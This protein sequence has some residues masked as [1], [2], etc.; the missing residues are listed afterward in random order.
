MAS[1]E[2][3]MSTVARLPTLPVTILVAALA[4]LPAGCY[5]ITWGGSSFRQEVDVSP[6]HELRLHPGIQSLRGVLP[7]WGTVVAD[8]EEWL[9]GFR[10]HGEVEQL[11]CALG[12]GDIHLDVHAYL[13][14]RVARAREAF[15]RE[16]ANIWPSRDTAGH[17]HGGAGDERYCVSEV[18]E[19]ENHCQVLLGRGSGSYSSAVVFQKGRAVITIEEHRHQRRPEKDVLIR[20]LAEALGPLSEDVWDGS[21]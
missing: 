16:C 5:I 12:H 8:G 7:E 11:F 13:F 21:P 6:L 18:R 3:P 1:R 4:L 14:W 20:E 19:G 17:V 9:R 10:K 2:K 15:D